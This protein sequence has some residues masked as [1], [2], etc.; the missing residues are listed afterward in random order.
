MVQ[1]VATV[2]APDKVER[3]QW[4]E[5]L[6]RGGLLSRSEQQWM[7]DALDA[8]AALTEKWDRIDGDGYAAGDNP[9]PFERTAELRSLLSQGASR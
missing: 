1:V 9:D 7:L 5:H 2:S 3:D 4:R 6:R 8:A